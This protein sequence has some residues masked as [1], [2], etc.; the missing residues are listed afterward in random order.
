MNDLIKISNHTKL[1]MGLMYFGVFLNA[2]TL[3]LPCYSVS[4][5]LFPSEEPCI[6]S[7]EQIMKLMCLVFG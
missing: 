5:G 7:Q 3:Q 4:D 1:R 6:L 2:G